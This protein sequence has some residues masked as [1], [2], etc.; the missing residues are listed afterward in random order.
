MVLMEMYN[1]EL[2]LDINSLFCELRKEVEEIIDTSKTY[3]VA[4]EMIVDIVASK[5]V[6]ESKGYV[7]DLYASLVNDIKKD[8]YF[9]N[10]NHLNDFYRLNL[11]EELNEKYNFEITSLD[12]YKKGIEFDE[13]NNL[14]AT[15]GAA[16]GTLAVGGIL[17]FAISGIVNIPFIVI[18]AGA[19]GA[20]L[21][22]NKAIIIQN[23]KE[24]KIVVDK[25]L[26][27]MEHEII[28]WLNDVADYFQSR[29]NSLRGSTVK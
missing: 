21:V 22:V 16:A 29:V 7:I 9:K 12:S 27:D 4:S 13:I 1:K 10:P 5:V 26:K 17:K 3:K 20:A 19:V 24:F 15:A 8:D 28:D 18:I 14:Y 23:K 11:R 6:T 25:F 2:E